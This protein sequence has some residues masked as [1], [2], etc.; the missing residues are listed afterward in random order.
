[1]DY[2]YKDYPTEIYSW[3]V[4]SESESAKYFKT[5][6]EAVNYANDSTDNYLDGS[7]NEDVETIL[8]GQVTHQ[9]GKANVTERPEESELDDDSEDANGI[10]W[11]EFEHRCDYI[12]YRL[13]AVKEE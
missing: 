3:F 11:G 12:M 4:S 9:A 10:Y 13:N 7:W 6:D 8:V 5:E 1:M 2:D